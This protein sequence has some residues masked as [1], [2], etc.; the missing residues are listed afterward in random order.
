ME[1]RAGRMEYRQKGKKRGRGKID[2]EG[3]GEEKE[4]G[5]RMKEKER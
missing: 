3:N 5:G 2:K 1:E 4:R